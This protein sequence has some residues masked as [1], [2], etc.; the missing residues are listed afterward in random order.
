M[1]LKMCENDVHF[2]N[3]TAYACICYPGSFNQSMKTRF[4]IIFG[5]FLVKTFSPNYTHKVLSNISLE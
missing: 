5:H 1:E 4:A 3:M 2:D